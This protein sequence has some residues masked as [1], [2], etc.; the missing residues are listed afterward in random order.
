MHKNSI[1]IYNPYNWSFFV[2]FTVNFEHIT[3]HFLFLF[4][5]SFKIACPNKF[6]HYFEGSLSL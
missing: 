5:V 1:K 2:A 3:Y 4:V 6:V